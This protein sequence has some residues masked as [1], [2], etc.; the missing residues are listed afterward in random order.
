MLEN[1]GKI[2]V[3][4]LDAMVD[5]C[6]VAGEAEMKLALKEISRANKWRPGRYAYSPR[7]LVFGVEERLPASILDA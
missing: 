6:P 4:A 2:A 5:Q 7:M 1:H 3:E